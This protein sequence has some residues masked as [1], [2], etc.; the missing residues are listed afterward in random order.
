MNL[1]LK[2][3][4]LIAALTLSLTGCAE[5]PGTMGSG[6][7]TDG[8]VKKVSTE[9]DSDADWAIPPVI[10]EGTVGIVLIE[11]GAWPASVKK[12]KIDLELS[13]SA[14]LGDLAYMLTKAGITTVVSDPKLA[15]KTV[16]L[17][18]YKGPLAGYADTISR[19]MD[20]FFSW[21]GTAL[22]V[23]PDERVAVSVPQDKDYMAKVADEIKSLGFTVTVA[24]VAGVLV[25]NAKTS[26]MPLLREYLSRAAKNAAMVNLQVGVVSVA[27][28]QNKQTGVDWSKLQLAV[29]PGASN[30]ITAATTQATTTTNIA[31]VNPAV[32]GAT[33]VATAVATATTSAA[34]A[35]SNVLSL[36]G[37]GIG[38]RMLSGRAFAMSGLMNFLETFGDAT[39]VQ[40][41]MMK[42]ITGKEVAL[43]STTN[44]PYASSVGISA[45]GGT[46]SSTGVPVGTVS[47]STA[48]A[49][50]QLKLT[51]AYDAY[52][53]I[54]TVDLNLAVNAIVGSNNVSAGNQ[55]GS[56]SQPTTQTQKFNGTVRL[57]PGE[58]AVIG[59]VRYSSTSD[60]RSGL[61]FLENTRT[62]SSTVSKSINEMFIVIR[63][64]VVLYGKEAQ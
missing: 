48:T 36:S 62:G 55:I 1:K 42:T 43:D 31:S 5:M 46:S 60:N 33:G 51:P 24:P 52:N 59:G 13:G 15:E 45:V 38:L 39:T 30:T 49:G 53:K 32:A 35:A 23:E 21:D 20:V 4:L 37:G 3:K 47:T 2:S 29:G 10:Q 26:E 40:N 25:V 6:L 22:V 16:P 54:V 19:A 17:L 34:T 7:S 28:S 58:T 12:H 63:P 9:L 57:R 14:T 18:N 41:V 44:V 27:L 61:S 50:I 56:L 11:P 8:A 64:S